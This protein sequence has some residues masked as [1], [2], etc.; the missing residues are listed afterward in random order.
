MF[1]VELIPLIDPG[2]HLDR[3]HVRTARYQIELQPTTYLNGLLL[4]QCAQHRRF[5]NA[6]QRIPDEV[7]V[8]FDF[9]RS[10][11]K[12]AY[13]HSHLRTFQRL[14]DRQHAA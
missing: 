5:G 3:Q 6:V 8:A 1:A 7:I 9:L 10:F 2:F 12:L 4:S 11:Q 13:L 14:A